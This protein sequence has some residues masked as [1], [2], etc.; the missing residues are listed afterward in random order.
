[1]NNR[2]V[3]C[4][5]LIV[6]YRLFVLRGQF[7]TLNKGGWCYVVFLSVQQPTSFYQ[8]ITKR[9]SR[10]GKSQKGEIEFRASQKGYIE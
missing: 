4:E 7:V 6:L 10:G 8:T 3:S 1:M 5:I 2:I 9:R